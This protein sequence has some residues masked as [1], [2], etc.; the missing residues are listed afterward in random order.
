MTHYASR[1][2]YSLI[3]L[4]TSYQKGSPA[5]HSDER[6]SISPQGWKHE[7]R[8]KC[9]ECDRRVVNAGRREG[10]PGQKVADRQDTYEELEVDGLAEWLGSAIGIEVVA[11]R[12]GEKEEGSAVSMLQAFAVATFLSSSSSSAP[13][14]CH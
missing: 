13:C 12:A 3:H 10:M 8:G 5:V 4:F 11:A 9:D 6:R 2:S 1:F 7:L 14:N